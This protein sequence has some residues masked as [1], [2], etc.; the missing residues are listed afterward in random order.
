MIIRC[1]RTLVLGGLLSACHGDGLSQ[2]ESTH[3]EGF[4]RGPGI[5]NADRP[6]SELFRPISPVMSNRHM[7]QPAVV[8]QS[9]FL[10]GNGIHEIWNIVN[11]EAP[12]KLSDLVSPFRHGEAE[13]HQVSFS[14][15]SDGSLHAVTISGRGIDLWNISDPAHPI[16]DKA[17]ELEG[18]NYG[19][20]TAAVW[21]VSWQGQYIFVGGT[22]TGLHIIDA[23]D[24]KAARLVKRIPVEA[25]GG[26]S[27]GP[28]FAVGNLLVVTTPKES[29]GVATLDISDPSRPVLLDTVD[30][31]VNSYIGSFFGTKAYMVSPLRSFDV[32]TDP[33]NI[34][35]ISSVET[36]STEYLSFADGHAFVGSLRRNAGGITGILKY[37]IKDP[38][39]P[40]QVGHVLGRP[41]EGTDDQFPLPIGNLLVVADDERL[42]GA[43]L[44]VHDTKKDSTAPEVLYVNPAP[45]SRDQALTTRIGLSFSDQ[46]ELSSVNTSTF[47]V[48]PRGGNPIPGRWGINQTVLSF[49]PETRL[50]PSTDYE[51]ILPAG[52][53][54]DLVGN[55]LKEEYR[56]TFRTAAGMEAGAACS[57]EALNPAPVH[58]QVQ[59]RTQ[60][61]AP[62]PRTL[63]WTFGDG[64]TAVGSTV[65]HE[66]SQPG[67]YPVT[68]TLS[69]PIPLFDGRVTLEA[70][71]AEKIG[72]IVVSNEH[73]SYHGSGYA[74]FPANFGSDVRLLFSGIHVQRAGLQQFALRFANAGGGPRRLSLLV[75]GVRQR[76]LEFPSGAAWN[77]WQEL[78]FDLNLTA[79]SHKLELRA[80]QNSPG[81]NIDQIGFAAVSGYSTRV[82]A[83]CSATQIIHRPLTPSKPEHSRAVLV[84]NGLAWTV[85]PDAD[86]VTAV[87]TTTFQ[88]RFEV[89]VGKRPRSL[90][91]ASNG[92]LWVV[93]QEG[94]SISIIDSGSGRLQQTVELPYGSRPFGIAFSPGGDA[95]YVSLEAL[96]QVI[97]LDPVQGRVLASLDLGPDANGMVPKPRALAISADGT[98][99]LVARFISPEPYP[100]IAEAAGEVYDV[101][102]DAWRLSRVLTLQAAKGID[103]PDRA[104]GLPNYLNAVV[105]SP[106]GAT[107]FVPSKQDNIS[108]GLFRDGQALTHDGTVRPILS[109]L[110]LLRQ[111]E[112]PRIDLNDAEMPI[113]VTMSPHGDLVFIAL[114]GSNKVEV[115]N[116]YTGQIVGSIQAGM[117]PQDLTLDARGR[118]YMQNFLDRTL[119]VVDAVPFLKGTDNF[120]RQLATISTVTVEPFAPDVLA[121]KKIFY[122]AADPRMSHESYISCASCHLDGDDDGRV[123]DFTDR[124]EGLRNSIS[125]SGRAGLEHGAMHWTANFDEVQDF[126]ND[127]RKNFRGKGF[128]DDELFFATDRRDPLGAPKAGLSPELDQLAAY[129]ASLDQFPRSP[130][131]VNK[132]QLSEG[133][134]AGKQLF[135]SLDC[136]SC[137]QGGSLRDGRSHDVGTL[138]MSSGKR[139]DGLL[140]GIDTP[141]LHGVW[142]T[143][144][145][146]HDGSAKTLL[147]VIQQKGH[148]NA[149]DLSQVQK[150]SLVEYLLQL[151][152]SEL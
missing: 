17:M 11:P 84:D 15:F 64:S 116:A 38:L 128:M 80:D 103:T 92:N 12:V 106:D 61:E 20:F 60:T 1:M 76:T 49:W 44:A 144:P 41:D 131:R 81:P 104:R 89:A 110:G 140:T 123:W 121:G 145:Y 13:S 105:I 85:N 3:R 67:R 87:D 51:V 142:A 149:Q 86:S 30:P 117:A 109:R 34:Q 88:K 35:L 152:G 148:G 25:L 2:L 62:A 77:Q 4:V 82:L 26:V 56:T 141:T 59:L 31:P 72:G 46:I 120:A 40:R 23:A 111:T 58:S 39:K 146:F 16:L 33:R 138:K 70:E 68:M 83:V 101:D 37:D 130:Y 95:A 107:A 133:G 134:R 96:G 102:L 57:I 22:N 73:A 143:A 7:N 75:D 9:L 6:E 97:K 69:E 14:R 98:R 66:Y 55:P 74:D 27:A 151:D 147:D 112:E 45:A 65:Q 63:T 127:I 36:P 24:P 54:S 118:L 42:Y 90:A 132:G 50:E 71:N 29:S 18:I 137:H 21:G 122:N 5:P 32:T 78:T 19:D 135:E 99:L 125:L 108:R 28:L 114:Q 115:R 48:R 10:A 119:Q 47:I 150:A 136:M 94:D 129:V 126:E 100:G 113:A 93:N 124:G 43:Y 8:N 79:G 53:I 91:K 139:R 52:G